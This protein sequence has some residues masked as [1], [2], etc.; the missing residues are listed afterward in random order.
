M[1]LIP[2]ESDSNSDGDFSS[3]D[4]VWAE[5]KGCATTVIR[6]VKVRIPT[7]ITLGYRE[8]QRKR[9][10]QSGQDAFPALIKE[11]LRAPSGEVIHDLYDQWKAA[12]MEYDELEIIIYWALARAQGNI[13]SFAEAISQLKEIR[14]GKGQT[15]PTTSNDTGGL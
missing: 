11:L 3:W 8:E 12:G 14:E 4:A 7:G 2:V 13:I 6:G 9:L 5:Y 1:T 15:E 10:A